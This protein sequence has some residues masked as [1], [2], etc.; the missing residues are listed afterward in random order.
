MPMR[1]PQV[2]PAGPG[3]E[4]VAQPAVRHVGPRRLRP[5]ALDMVVVALL[6]RA[7]LGLE[8]QHLRAILAHRAVHRGRAVQDLRHPLGEGRQHLGVVVEIARLHEADLR[9]RLRHHVG[10]AVDPVDQ[11]A[12]E[13]EIGEHH[14]AAVAELRRML[15]RR[16]HQRE[17]HAGVADLAPAEAHPLPQEPRHLRDVAVRVRVR[18]APPDHHQQRLVPRHRAV[19]GVGPGAGLLD[20]LGGGADHLR[21]HPQLAP[22]IHPDPVG[23]GIGVQHRGNVVLRVHRREQHPWHRENARAPRLAQLVEPVAQHRVGELQVPVLDRPL[24]RQEGGQLLGQHR[25]LV[26]R[27]LRARAMPADHHADLLGDRPGGSR[28]SA[29]PQRGSVLGRGLGHRASSR[30]PGPDARKT[31]GGGRP[32][33][34]PVPTTVPPRPRD[35]SA[36]GS[37]RSASR[38]RP[39]GGIS[40]PPRGQARPRRP[41][42]RLRPARDPPGA[43]H[44]PD[45]G[46]DAGAITWA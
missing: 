36:H 17:G 8:P 5:L 27:G 43:R 29:L 31:G 9:M 18:G 45:R 44:R 32:R 4:V 22:V 34:L 10:E 12:R 6:G 11:H 28:P 30:L 39:G 38:R 2:Q 3:A 15:Q 7:D 41:A 20:P 23:P 21:V 33:R 24:R 26:H 46:P 14:D 37:F 16:L 19:L 40:A 35:G 13:Q 1:M 42:A 25:E